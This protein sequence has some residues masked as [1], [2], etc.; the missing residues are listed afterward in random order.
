MY[1][2][3]FKLSLQAVW[4]KGSNFL[5]TRKWITHLEVNLHYRDFVWTN[6]T[7]NRTYSWST[8]LRSTLCVSNA[9]A[10]DFEPRTGWNNCIIRVLVKAAKRGMAP[11]LT[12]PSPP[13]ACFL[14][15]AGQTIYHM[16]NSFTLILAETEGL[17]WTVQQ[18]GTERKR[19]RF[20]DCYCISLEP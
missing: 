19:H 5:F 11:C 15:A 2:S 13:S 1:T 20:F 9:G 8:Q 18:S 16:A 10:K 7:T 12:W 14:S 17:A 4:T 6:Y 3:T